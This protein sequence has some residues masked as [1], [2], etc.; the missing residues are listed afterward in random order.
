MLFLLGAGFNIEATREAGPFYGNSIYSGVHRID[1]SY[2]LVADVLKLCFGLDKAPDGKSVEDLFSAAL[3]A[4]DYKPM[5]ALVERLMAA[6]YYIA[7]RLA[8]SQTPNSYTKFFQHFDG[9]Q[10][11]TFNY[12]SL[13]EVFLSRSGGWFPEDGYGVPVQTESAFLAKPETRGKSVSLVVHLHGS[14]CVFTIESRLEGNPVG[15]VAELIHLDE[16]LYAFDPDSISHCFPQYRRVMSITGH[17]RPDQRVIAPIPDK[18]RNLQEAF[19]QKSCD[20]A[21]R[22]VRKFGTLVAIG[23]SFN[24]YDR[25]SYHR[26]LET[27]GQSGDR[28]LFVVALEAKRVGER[29]SPQYPSIKIRPIEKTFGAWAM[30]SFDL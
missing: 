11:L 15:G 23:Y 3:Q 6:D 5:E 4:G 2:P 9:T 17:T 16:P 24:A 22:L 18:S 26:L 29:L 21:L 27:L 10:F 19:I 7:Q 12:D 20:V 13:P 28:T 1:C 14:A 30:D 25:V 8:T